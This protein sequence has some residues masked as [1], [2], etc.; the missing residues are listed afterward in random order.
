MRELTTRLVPLG[1]LRPH[2]ENANLG[3]VAAVRESLRL[4]GQWRPLVAQVRDGEPLRVLIGHT[5]LRAAQAEGWDRL[6]VHERACDDDEARRILAIDNR[7]RDLAKT[8]EAALVRL[9]GSLGDDL[10]GTGYTPDD[11]D[12]YRALVE[13]QETATL[14]AMREAAKAD[15]RPTSQVRTTPTQQDHLVNYDGK[16][17]RHLALIYP[18]PVFVWLVDHLAKL[19]AD[20]GVDSNAELVLRLVEQ[21][22]NAQAPPMTADDEPAPAAQPDTDTPPAGPAFVEPGTVEA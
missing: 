8:D 22:V 9:L 1:E 3:D 13:E 16:G 2:P 5:M 12:N 7:S 21:R 20:L 15:D 14:R 10:A 11:L 4:Y 19:A 17:T 18:V 6:S